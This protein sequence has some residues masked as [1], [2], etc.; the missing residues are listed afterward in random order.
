MRSHGVVYTGLKE[1]R[2]EEPAANQSSS[3]NQEQILAA[4][5]DLPG[6]VCAVDVES[7]TV[8]PCGLEW[9]SPSPCLL[10][11][12]LVAGTF[13]GN[14]TQESSSGFRNWID[15]EAF[16]KGLLMTSKFTTEDAARQSPSTIHR[17]GFHL[18]PPTLSS[19]SLLPGGRD[20]SPPVS[21]YIGSFKWVRFL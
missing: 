5:G 6:K 14:S 21:M 18:D 1:A 4:G 11:P 13:T 8:L 20:L 2:K 16:G 15:S 9:T 10:F 12:T 7:N 17:T 3:S 19:P